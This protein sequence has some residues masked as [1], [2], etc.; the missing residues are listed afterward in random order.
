[1]A[2]VR[3]LM[4]RQLIAVGPE[5]SVAHTIKFLANHNLGS[6]PVVND[7]GD[8]VGT[9][10]ELML[11]DIVFNETITD[12]P[13]A[14]YMTIGAHVV[15]PNDSLA[16]AA[17]LFALYDIQRVPVVE[18]GKLVGGLARCDLMNYVLRTGQSLADPSDNPVCTGGISGE[19]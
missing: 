8:I 6:A 10:S 14:R 18:D 3:Q 12:V 4:N 2:T 17:R 16:R 9:I 5:T 1:M 7:N 15:Q 19:K 13:V 11:I